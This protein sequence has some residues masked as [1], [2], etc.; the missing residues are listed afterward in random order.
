MLSCCFEAFGGNS[1][2]TSLFNQK[3]T[4]SEKSSEILRKI[5]FLNKFEKEKSQRKIWICLNPFF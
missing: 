4:I 5:T 3:M 2:K 1:L